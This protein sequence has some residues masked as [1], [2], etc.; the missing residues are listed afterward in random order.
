MA[1]TLVVDTGPTHDRRKK[2]FYTPVPSLDFPV[3]VGKKNARDDVMLVQV[4]LGNI[5]T[6]QLSF[7][8][9]TAFKK[10]FVGQEFADRKIKVDGMFGDETRLLLHAVASK[11]LHRTE[12]VVYPL[13]QGSSL[14]S[15]SNT[16]LGSNLMGESVTACAVLGTDAPFIGRGGVQCAFTPCPQLLRAALLHER[17]HY[18]EKWKSQEP[19]YIDI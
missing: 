19:G 4:W 18:A 9:D 11:V 6:Y 10:T 5:A 7:K 2:H 16:T 8:A 12:S 15:W 1:F 3:G 14:G 13:I 17:R